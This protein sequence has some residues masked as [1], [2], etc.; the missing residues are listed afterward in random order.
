[1]A[2][3][4]LTG[5]LTPLVRAAVAATGAE[6][7]VRGDGST[8]VTVTKEDGCVRDGSAGGGSGQG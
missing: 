8:A 7:R 2:A 6:L 1:M 5:A 4:E 3:V